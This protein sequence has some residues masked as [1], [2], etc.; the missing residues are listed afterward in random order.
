M[1]EP[2]IR[3]TLAELGSCPSYDCP[4]FNNVNDFNILLKDDVD[5]H[6]VS[7]V[8]WLSLE[9]QRVCK[10]EECV[11]KPESMEDVRSFYME[12]SSLLREL[13]C[14]YSAFTGGYLEETLSN[15]AQR[16]LLINYLISELQ[17]GCMIESRIDRPSKTCG[18]SAEPS[19]AGSE[20][21]AQ[22]KIMLVCLGFPKPPPN[23]TSKQL[24]DKVCQKVTEHISKIPKGNLGD[25]L[26]TGVLSEKQWQTLNTI[27]ETMTDEYKWREDVLLKRLDVT[28]LSFT[29]CDRLK[30]KNN[31]F[32][33]LLN[34]ANC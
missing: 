8:N 30:V 11:H 2:D 18:V 23:I 29:W 5:L 34:M 13:K 32:H 3:S 28:I 17:A 12:L 4:L 26:F 24:F 14:P 21:A 22:L 15:E 10:L 33:G 16:L 9:L 27:N 25:A 19:C 6:F 31:F 20:T 1:I 7:L